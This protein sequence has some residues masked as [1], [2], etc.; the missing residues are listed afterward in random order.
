M[1]QADVCGYTVYKWHP[2]QPFKV[3]LLDRATGEARIVLDAGYELNYE[4]THKYNFE[5]AAYDC[6]TGMHADRFFVLI[7]FLFTLFYFDLCFLQ[8]WE[9][10]LKYHFNI[11]F[12]AKLK[13]KKYYFT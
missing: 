1:F 6:I 13:L 5:I 10:H 11:C 4:K 7:Q 12:G 3:D 2:D 8:T 9:S